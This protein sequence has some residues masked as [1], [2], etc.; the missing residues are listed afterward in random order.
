M[1]GGGGHGHGHGGHGHGGGSHDPPAVT[2]YKLDKLRELNITPMKIFLITCVYNG[3]LAFFFR[4][5]FA[6]SYK[7]MVTDATGRAPPTTKADV[8]LKFSFR[9]LLQK[10]VNF[11]R[12][13]QKKVLELTMDVDEEEEEAE[14]GHAAVE[15]EAGGAA[16]KTTPRSLL[17]PPEAT[18]SS[19]SAMSNT[20][21][22]PG[23][24][25]IMNP[26]SVLASV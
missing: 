15:D 26:L 12:Y 20:T 11:M 24:T 16:K 8:A 17:Q 5:R 21:R 25:V 14:A 4:W 3:V 18:Y 7:K 23:G 2:L 6:G 19:S 22:G 13:L 10:M 9:L 1:G